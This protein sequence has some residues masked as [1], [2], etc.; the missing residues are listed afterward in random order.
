[1]VHPQFATGDR[2]L[3]FWKALHE[4]WP[5]SRQQCCWVH[6]IANDL[7]KL[8]S[9]VRGKAKK[10]LHAI[11]QAENWES[12]EKAFDRFITKYGAM[13]GKAT[14]CLVKERAAPLAIYVFPVEP[15]RRLPGKVS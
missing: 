8:P 15:L 6:K 3:G 7:K 11:Y 9:S 4:A 12:A 5:K 13:H 2:G 10:D 1:M 14:G